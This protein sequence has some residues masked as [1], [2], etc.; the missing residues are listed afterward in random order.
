PPSG[1]RTPAK[2]FPSVDL[3]APFSPTRACTD[4]DRTATVASVSALV[5]PKCWDTPRASRK[6]GSPGESD[7]GMAVLLPPAGRRF[8]PAHLEVP[9]LAELLASP[10]GL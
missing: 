7:S 6:P 4:P 10:A 8:V 9:R 5:P 2:I 3:P 1:A